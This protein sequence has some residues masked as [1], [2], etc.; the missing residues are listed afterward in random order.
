VLT[1][2]KAEYGRVFLRL[3]VPP[4]L[5]EAVLAFELSGIV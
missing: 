3:A 1:E 5:L 4:P 2:R